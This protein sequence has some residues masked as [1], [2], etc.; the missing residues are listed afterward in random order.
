MSDN[1]MGDDNNGF[2]APPAFKADEVLVGL[3]RQLR[4]LKLGERGSAFEWR[5][6]RVA[7]FAVDA[8]ALT[9]RLAKRPAMT[10]DWDRFT[11]KNSADV[12]KYVDELKKRLLR[13]EDAE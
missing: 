10:P 1:S 12:R 13:W 11:L 6:K 3:K 9:A 4:D 5:G 2:F 8:G 7:E